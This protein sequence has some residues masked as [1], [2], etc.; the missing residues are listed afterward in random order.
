MKIS[1]KIKIPDKLGYL[2]I[3]LTVL[4]IF[5]DEVQLVSSLYSND[6]YHHKHIL[7]PDGNYTLEWTVLWESKTIVFNVSAECKGYIGMGLS[8][9]GSISG[10]DFVIGGIDSSGKPYFSVSSKVH[11]RTL[12]L[13]SYRRL[14]IIFTYGNQ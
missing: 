6:A 10:S 1:T 12:K 5:A 14:T 2:V 11:Q 3:S 4:S 13:F 7:G 8:K 9:T